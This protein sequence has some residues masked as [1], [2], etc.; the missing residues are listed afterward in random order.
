MEQFTTHTKKVVKGGELTAALKRV[1]DDR[2]DLAYRVYND[3]ED[4]YSQNLTQQ[5]R[6]AWLKRDLAVAN[7]IESGECTSFTTIQSLNEIITGE[8]IGFLS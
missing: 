5:Q 2:R 3:V 4:K 7:K 1:A 6:D 8:C